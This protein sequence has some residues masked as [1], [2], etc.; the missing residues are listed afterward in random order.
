MTAG[1]DFIPQDSDFDQGPSYPTVFGVTI[2]PVVSGVLL[3][4]AGVI[5]AAA[6]WAYVVSPAWESYQTLK[7]D[8]E[9]KREQVNQIAAVK[10]QVADAK[11][12]L[13][14][15]NQQ[16]DQVYALFANEK[17]LDT[18][19]YDLNQLIEKNNAG[20]VVATQSK[21]NNCPSW[22]RDQYANILT[23]QKF[24]DQAGALIAEAKLNRFEPNPKG[25]EVITDSSLGPA[26]NNKL[27]RQS[28]SVDFKGNFNQTQSIFRTIERLQPLLLVKNLSVQV[29]TGTGNKPGTVLYE[30]GPGGSV[31]FLT[32][33]QPD[34]VLT[35]SF[36]ME[37][38]L[39]LSAADRKALAP[40]PVVSPV[41]SPK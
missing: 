9:A 2:T 40:S 32:N 10:K 41:A 39:P 16:R 34:A 29:G 14:Q 25:A 18:L 15:V 38:L 8:V 27:K 28:V 17:T 11:T 33:C 23:Y 20:R 22:V 13:T 6:L 21:L 5:G 1:G 12:K 26:I 3:A 37:A 31:R 7:A 35:T 24:E 19:L 36:Q 30:T 4:T